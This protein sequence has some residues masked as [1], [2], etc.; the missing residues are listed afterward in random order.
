MG[1]IRG[2]FYGVN[3]HGSWFGIPENIDA[4]NDGIL[5]DSIDNLTWHKEKLLKTGIKLIRFDMY[6]AKANK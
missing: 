5:G 6:L 4:N 2:D 3:T 1:I